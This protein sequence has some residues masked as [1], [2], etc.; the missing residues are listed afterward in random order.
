MDHIDSSHI[1]D[2][3]RELADFVRERN[4]LWRSDPHQLF[5]GLFSKCRVRVLLVTDGFQEAVSPGQRLFG[6]E[7][8]LHTVNNH[9]RESAATIIDQLYRSILR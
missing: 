7:R 5:P 9:R 4:Q 3:N 1:S 6:L 8:V 2:E